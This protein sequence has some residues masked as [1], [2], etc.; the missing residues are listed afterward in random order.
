MSEVLGLKMKKVSGSDKFKEWFDNFLMI[1]ERD[2]QDGPVIGR[3][4]SDCSVLV[5]LIRSSIRGEYEINPKPKSIVTLGVFI[6]E[7]IMKQKNEEKEKQRK[8]RIDLF[9][10]SYLLLKEELEDYK[11]WR[12]LKVGQTNISP[13]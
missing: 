8:N 13:C 10:K 2:F 11:A 7:F 5:Q 6:V 9:E 4:I 12:D 1:C 3:K